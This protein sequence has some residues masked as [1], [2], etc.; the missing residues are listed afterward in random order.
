MDAMIAAHESAAAAHHSIRAA[1]RLG[2]VA[3]L[4]NSRVAI[5]PS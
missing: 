4:P 2:I 1:P 3:K 5:V